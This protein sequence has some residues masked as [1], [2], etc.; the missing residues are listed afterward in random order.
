MRG[1][2]R[3]AL[4]LYN[5]KERIGGWLRMLNTGGMYLQNKARFPRETEVYVETL[6]PMDGGLQALRVKGWV[7]YDDNH[8]MGIQFDTPDRE[9]RTLIASLMSE[10][11]IASA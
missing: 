3:A 11:S 8:G 10:F 6:V 4:F 9:T 7:A 2:L 1:A 5:G